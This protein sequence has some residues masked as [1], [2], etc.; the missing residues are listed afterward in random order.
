MLKKITQEEL[1]RLLELHKLWLQSD[2]KEGSKLIISFLDLSDL[3]L[4]N[5]SF[6]Q[7]SIKECNLSNSDLSNSDFSNADLTGCDF[8]HTNTLN[9]NFTNTKLVS[10]TGLES[11]TT[12]ATPTL[13]DNNTST[14]ADRKNNGKPQLSYLSLKC[15]EP[16]ARVMELAALTKYDRNNWKK[17]MKTSELVDSLMRHIEDILEGKTID[18]ESGLPIVGHIQ[19]NAMFLGNSNNVDD[20]NSSTEEKE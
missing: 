6:V 17:G 20:L 4:S 18:D 10:I 11:N 14:L 12:V 13:E 1:D 3:N 9:T 15:L 2:Y 8:T 5:R 7:S 16:C 19:A